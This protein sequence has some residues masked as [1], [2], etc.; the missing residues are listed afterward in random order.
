MDCRTAAPLLHPYL[1]GELD[2]A[3][4]DTL[5]AHLAHCPD[6]ARE[7]ATLEA[8]RKVIR[9]GAPRHAAPPS[10]RNRLQ[11]SRE[12]SAQPMSTRGR[13]APGWWAIAAS[14]LVA[15]GL[16]AGSMVWRTAQ[17]AATNSE[18]AFA[19][20]LFAS[21]LRA[22]AAA[23]PVDVVSSNRHTVKPWFAGKI[24]ISPPVRDLSAEGFPLVGGR[25][26]YV[27][28]Q[29]VAVLAYSHGQH[30]IDVY[31]LPSGQG[32]FGQSPLLIQGYRL[33]PIQLQGQTAWVVADVDE[34]EFARFKQALTTTEPPPQ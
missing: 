19:H 7:L 20:D 30:L 13:A 11:T 22:L 8:L 16:G 5:E 3:S 24:G 15:F 23:S 32:D 4:V 12:D 17:M 6:C 26:D 28:E 1:D 34:H 31:L 18:H 10:L 25:I 14:L 33:A 9:E 21:H 2:R 29:R 27:G